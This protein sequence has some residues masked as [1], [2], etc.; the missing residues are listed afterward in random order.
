MLG[1]LDFE[2]PKILTF[3]FGEKNRNYSYNLL[4]I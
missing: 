3:S 1:P 4:V 2:E